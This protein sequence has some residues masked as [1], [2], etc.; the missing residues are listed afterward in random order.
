MDLLEG[1]ERYRPLWDPLMG[2][3]VLSYLLKG[4][5]VTPPPLLPSPILHPPH[6]PPVHLHVY[7]LA[8]DL[9][10]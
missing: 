2:Q 5:L 9:P 10:L 6:L 3:N 8:V 1:Q 7:F 4:R